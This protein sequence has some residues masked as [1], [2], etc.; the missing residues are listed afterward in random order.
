MANYIKGTLDPKIKS[1]PGSGKWCS[2]KQEAKYLVYKRAIEAALEL[3]VGKTLAG[4][5]AD[6]HLQHFFNN[7]G[8]DLRID[9]KTMIDRVPSLKLFY[10]QELAEAK[11]FASNLSTG[12][13]WIT[14]SRLRSGYA[15]KSE[16][17][18]WYYAVGGYAY[19]GKA[20]V[21]VINASTHKTV[22]VNFEFKLFDRYNWDKGKKVTIGGQIVT[23]NFMQ[24]FHRQ[25]Y[26]KEFNVKG[27]Y[28]KKYTFKIKNGST[29]P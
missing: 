10:E 26:A 7:T 25:C 19:W 18:N 21:N 27:S 28:L 9:L 11:A 4:E 24:N 12:S 16:N 3:R 15:R 22:T 5:D 2:D 23:D 6:K 14:S 13:H 20:K 8:N 1:D 17:S 29:T